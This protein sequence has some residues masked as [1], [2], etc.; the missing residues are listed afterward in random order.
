MKT[1]SFTPQYGKLIKALWNAGSP[2]TLSLSEI[3]LFAG[4]GAYGNHS[5][6][7]YPDWDLV[8]DDGDNSHRRLTGRGKLFAQ[9]QLAIPKEVDENGNAIPGCS[10]ITI[11]DL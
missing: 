10:Q 5:K 4:K 7:S 8:E 6:L 11:A 3:D 9:G 2:R 1:Y